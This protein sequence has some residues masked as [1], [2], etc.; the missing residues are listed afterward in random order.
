[1][2]FENFRKFLKVA[3]GILSFV[4]GA[5]F[6]TAVGV[7]SDF[8]AA[9]VADFFPLATAAAFGLLGVNLATFAETAGAAALAPF[10]ADAL[11]PAFATLLAP[12]LTLA[13]EDE[14]ATAFALA[15]PRVTT[16][17]VPSLKFQSSFPATIP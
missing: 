6:L 13:A 16:L 11:A 10:L 3:I 9:G 5:L 2:P 8:L 17:V 12:P 1:M 15:P 4:A 14:A 7:G